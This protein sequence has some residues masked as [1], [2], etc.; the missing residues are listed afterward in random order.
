MVKVFGD[1]GWSKNMELALEVR[2]AMPHMCY[3]DH[4]GLFRPYQGEC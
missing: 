3:E 4:E 1:L 2:G